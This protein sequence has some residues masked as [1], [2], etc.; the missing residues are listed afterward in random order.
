MEL[1]IEIKDYM[2]NAT[3][4]RTIDIYDKKDVNKIYVLGVKIQRILFKNDIL[5]R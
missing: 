1:H 3:Q 4:L 5:G 2:T